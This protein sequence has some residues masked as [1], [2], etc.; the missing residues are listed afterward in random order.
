MDEIGKKVGEWIALVEE[1]CL[2]YVL[3]C[4][5][6]QLTATVVQQTTFNYCK[7]RMTVNCHSW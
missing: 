5:E 2:K 3:T 7:Q 6:R 1:S 4:M